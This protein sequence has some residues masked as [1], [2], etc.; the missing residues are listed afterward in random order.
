MYHVLPIIAFL[1][2]DFVDISTT[3]N[4]TVDGFDNFSWTKFE[5]KY[6]N[7]NFG[8]TILFCL[9]ASFAAGLS[10]V[11]LKYWTIKEEAYKMKV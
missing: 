7:W 11:L 3:N 6:E 4:D 1:L 9:G 2:Y 5:T 8:K 10:Q